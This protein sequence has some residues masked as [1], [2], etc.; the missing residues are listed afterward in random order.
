MKVLIMK[1]MK[2]MEKKSS[3]HK[4]RIFTK[5]FRSN[6]QYSRRMNWSEKN[7][8]SSFHAVIICVTDGLLKPEHQKLL[9]KEYQRVVA[10]NGRLR[11][12]SLI[13]F[14][15]YKGSVCSY[16]F[17]KKPIGVRMGRGKAN[18]YGIATPVYK[19]QDLMVFRRG[20]HVGLVEK[21]VTQLN[22]KLPIELKM[23][24]RSNKII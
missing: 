18:I 24:V 17:S 16:P 2:N 11:K 23:I 3:K 19:G 21:L 7:V 5:F 4:G 20:I 6:S 9:Q 13:N 12:R 15:L 22:Y 8:N 14:G 10:Y 1:K